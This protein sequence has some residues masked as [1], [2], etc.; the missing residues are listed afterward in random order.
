MKRS[1]DITGADLRETRG[2]TPSRSVLSMRLSIADAAADG[3]AVRKLPSLVG[4]E[5]S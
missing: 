4:V 3:G 1:P 2:L 5:V